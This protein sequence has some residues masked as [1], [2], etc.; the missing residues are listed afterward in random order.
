M[1]ITKEAIKSLPIIGMIS[2]RNSGW[3]VKLDPNRH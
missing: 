2:T 3:G 1:K